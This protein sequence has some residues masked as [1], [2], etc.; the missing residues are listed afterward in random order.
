MISHTPQVKNLEIKGKKLSLS[1]QE[2]SF[3]EVVASV[4][5]AELQLKSECI[6]SLPFSVTD[7]A[8]ARNLF[9]KLKLIGAFAQC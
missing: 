1:S 2:S 6:G 9:C 7:H 8:K 5:S 3:S 4:S